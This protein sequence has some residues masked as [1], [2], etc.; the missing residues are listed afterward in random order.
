MAFE[1][2]DNAS[3]V[4]K[5]CLLECTTQIPN[6]AQKLDE[7]FKTRTGVDPGVD[8]KF[9]TAKH[10]EHSKAKS[11]AQ[12]N[13]MYWGKPPGQTQGRYCG[14]CTKHYMKLS[15]KVVI[16]EQVEA[17]EEEASASSLAG[18]ASKHNNKHYEE[19]ARASALAAQLGAEM[20]QDAQDEKDDKDST[21]SEMPDLVSWEE[22][23]W[24]GMA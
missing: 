4:H 9:E 16:A 1:D 22:K 10:A 8:K 13:L 6:L 23:N 7:A 3:Q 18:R 17:H 2:K 5:V 12:E 14:Y 11:Q 19:E 21:D 20:R 15:P 24:R